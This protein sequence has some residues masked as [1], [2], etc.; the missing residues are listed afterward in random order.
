MNGLGG[1]INTYPGCFQGDILI[2]HLHISIQVQHLI[3]HIQDTGILG[4]I[5]YLGFKITDFFERI[6][7]R[8]SRIDG[9]DK[10]AAI[11]GQAV[12]R[13]AI[14]SQTIQLQGVGG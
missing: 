11:Q 8:F 5:F 9:R 6:L 14:H 2:F 10:G 12:Q 1:K 3:D 4:R 7:Y 13:Q